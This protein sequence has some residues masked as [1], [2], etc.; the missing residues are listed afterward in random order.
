[1]ADVASY[2]VTT[3]IDESPI[4]GQQW[5]VLLISL[6]T[7]M[8]DGYDTQGIAYVAPVMAH[9]L[10]FSPAL[11][12]PIFSSG[13]AGLTLGALFFG[14][15]ADKIGRK[16]AIIWPMAIFGVFS[17]ATPLGHDVQS[18][19]ILRFIA[20]FGLGGTLPNVTA[21]VLE[22]A[23]RRRRALLVNSTAAF[24]AFGSIISGSL[25]NILIPTLGWQSTFYVGGIVPLLSIVVVAIYL[26]ESVRYLLL[27]HQSMEH[28]AAIMRRIVPARNFPA[29]TQFT[30]E[31]QIP[32]ITVKALFA[33]GR[34]YPTT[35][36]WI[37]FIANL[38]ILTY[39]VFWLPS[40]L[41]QVGQPLSVAI[42]VTICYAIGGLVGGLGM[43]WLA[44]KLGSLPKVLATAYGCAAITICVA[45]FSLSNTP[46]LIIAMFLTGCC[47]NGGQ[48]SLNTISAIFYPTAIR[49]TGIGWALGV[50]RIGAV[51]GPAIGGI[52][53]GAAWAPSNVVVANIVPAV[54]G[55]IAIVLFHLRHAALGEAVAAPRVSGAAG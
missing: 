22:Y 32:G 14:M 17:L 20:G 3:V 49:A 1:M 19:V 4:S 12:G 21:Y 29:G 43:G 25:A 27:A 23:P 28:A 46:V 16:Q 10:G 36:L 39:L 11:L 40:L 48:G 45:A 44:D 41:R 54:I 42:L 15:L 7:A 2:N 55:V 31:P 38:F 13:L 33:D 50:G 34:A 51:I 30:L 9:D 26:P 5:T 6:F 47:I 18:L 37:A 53:V 35:M 8:F 52:L 24:F